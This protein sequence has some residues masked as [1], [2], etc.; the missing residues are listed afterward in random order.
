MTFLRRYSYSAIAFM[1]NFLVSACV[2]LCVPLPIDH[3]MCQ[4]ARAHTIVRDS[5]PLMFCA[6]IREAG[7]A[8]GMHG[9]RVAPVF[10]PLDADVQLRSIGSH[11]HGAGA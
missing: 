4:H 3:V 1:I 5:I 6:K 11:G 2:V 10:A 9:G 8:S 7:A